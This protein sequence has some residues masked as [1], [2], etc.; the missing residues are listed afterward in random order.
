MPTTIT[1]EQATAMVR[2]ALSAIAPDADL[3]G[4]APDDDLRGAVELDSL[5]FLSFVEKL[6]Q[7]SGRRIEEDD[8]E[9][10]RSLSSCVAFLSHR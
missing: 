4:L 3:D 7:R 6:S 9:E 8:Y 2:E 10:L 5:D 1:P